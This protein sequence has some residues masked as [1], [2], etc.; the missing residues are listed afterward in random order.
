MN[1]IWLILIIVVAVLDL[2]T[3]N[4]L[5]SWIGIGFLAAWLAGFYVD[6]WIQMLIAFLIGLVALIIGNRISRKYIKRNIPNDPILVDKIIGN[7]FIAEKE[8]TGSAQQKVN[9]IYR[10]LKNIGEPVKPEERFSVLKI[11]DNKLIIRKEEN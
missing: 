1:W 6:F 7:T 5:F 3:S 4:V 2:M 10:N 8:I 9:G 11:E